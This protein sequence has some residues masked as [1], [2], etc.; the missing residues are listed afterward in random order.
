M[1]F[2]LRN[3]EHKDLRGGMNT[4]SGIIWHTGKEGPEVYWSAIGRD[5]R[6]FV[7]SARWDGTKAEFG[8]MFE[9]KAAAGCR[10]G[11]AK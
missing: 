3:I 7:V 4:Y 11:P 5:N 6:S 8:R 10:Y 1:K 2:V 9:Y